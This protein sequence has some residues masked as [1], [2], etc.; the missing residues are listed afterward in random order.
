MHKTKKANILN[1]FILVFF[2]WRFDTSVENYMAD[3]DV[4]VYKKVFLVLDLPQRVLWAMYGVKQKLVFNF[5]IVFETA[6]LC[7]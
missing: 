3:F 7:S 1:Y 6:A 2:S 5:S 4:N